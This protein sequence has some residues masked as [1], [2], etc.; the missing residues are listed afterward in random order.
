MEILHT[1]EIKF[2]NDRSCIDEVKSY[3]ENNWVFSVYVFIRIRY[4]SDLDWCYVC[5]RLDSE[6]M[7]FDSF[8]WEDDWDEGQQHVE[9]LA[10]ADLNPLLD[11][12]CDNLERS[13]TR[14]FGQPSSGKQTRFTGGD[15]K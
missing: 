7:E 15:K 4:D 13:H 5:S 14:R 6:S 11:R 8:V 12:I 1:D 3:M 9:Y 2:I 10:F